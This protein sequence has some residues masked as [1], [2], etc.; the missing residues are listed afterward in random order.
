MIPTTNYGDYILNKVLTS[1][2]IKKKLASILIA[3]VA[4]LIKLQV[5]NILSLILVFNQIV[6]FIMVIIITVILSIYVEYFYVLLEPYNDKFYYLAKYLIDNYSFENYI[7][8]KRI[9]MCILMAY[10]LIIV[11]VFEINNR[12]IQLYIGQYI[13]CF[14]IIDAYEQRYF[15]SIYERYKAK[16]K[17]VLYQR[18]PTF[19][20]ESYIDKQVDKRVDLSA[21]FLE[22]RSKIN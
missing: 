2:F 17:I 1:K 14:L 6:D 4:N 16:P 13:I 5:I 10:G 19:L 7:Y 3:L 15:H 22:G 8:W 9:I 21:S 20:I 18:M 11:T 12:V